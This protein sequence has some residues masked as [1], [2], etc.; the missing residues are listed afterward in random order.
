MKILNFLL[1]AAIIGCYLENVLF[2]EVSLDGTLGQAD[3]LTGPDFQI[4]ADF[5]RQS[6]GNLFHS[7]LNFNLNTGE[8]AVFS[9]PESVNNIITRV[10][11]GELSTINGGLISDIPGA[12][13]FF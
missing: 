11:G 7:F 9:G 10:T 4:S 13:L 5:G 2:A 3:I 1:L 6:G 8:T 12:N